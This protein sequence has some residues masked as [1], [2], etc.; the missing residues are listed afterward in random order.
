MQRMLQAGF[1]LRSTNTPISEIA[2][3]HSNNE[4]DIFVL[5]SVHRMPYV[6]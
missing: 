3:L 2:V 1:C 4:I 5:R 6:S